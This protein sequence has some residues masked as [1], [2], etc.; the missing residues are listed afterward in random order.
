MYE[1]DRV[2][3]A[4]AYLVA[5]AETTG[6]GT[7]VSFDRSIDRVDTIERV[8][9]PRCDARHQP[10]VSNVSTTLPTLWPPSTRRCASAIR[11]NG[12]TASITGSSTPCS[13]SDMSV[14]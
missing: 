1:T 13:A 7:I 4:E 11:S 9:P 3:F 14:W 5:C 10:P 12:R 6:V 2:D 8:E